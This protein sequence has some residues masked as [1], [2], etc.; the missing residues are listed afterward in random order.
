MQYHVIIIVIYNSMCTVHTPYIISELFYV[1]LILF[2]P[3]ISH[4]GSLNSMTC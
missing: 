4:L 1:F 2:D 3:Y